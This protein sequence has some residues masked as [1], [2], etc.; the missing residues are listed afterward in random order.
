MPEKVRCR[1]VGASS[2]YLGDPDP[3]WDEGT[4]PRHVV[5]CDLDGPQVGEYPFEFRVHAAQVMKKFHVP[6]FY[7]FRTLKGYH[8]VSFGI[9]KRRVAERIQERFDAW[10]D[11]ELHRQMFYNNQESVTR[12]T[13][14]P[15]EPEG[16]RFVDHLEHPGEVNTRWSVPHLAFWRAHMADLPTP[17]TGQAIGQETDPVKLHAYSTYAWKEDLTYG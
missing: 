3:A 5:F 17:S 16:I 6:D 1:V 13:A 2:L 11:D 12:I 10:G 15:G 4:L 7:L 8:L 9:Y 14:K